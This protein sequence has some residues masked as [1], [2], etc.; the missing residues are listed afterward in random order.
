MKAIRTVTC[1]I[2]KKFPPRLPTLKG[3]KKKWNQNQDFRAQQYFSPST[4]DG[5]T[6]SFERHSLEDTPIPTSPSDCLPSPPPPPGSHAFFFLRVLFGGQPLSPKAV[7]NYLQ[8]R[9]G[10]RRC[11]SSCL[12]L[13]FSPKPVLR[14]RGLLLQNDFRVCAP[15]GQG[16]ASCCTLAAK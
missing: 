12:S 4:A 14:V 7:I 8:S 1:F 11:R 2:G 13:A 15:E 6:V 5:H 10:L 9:G 16:S 3:K